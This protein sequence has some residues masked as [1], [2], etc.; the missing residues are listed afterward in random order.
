MSERVTMELNYDWRWYTHASLYPIFRDVPVSWKSLCI[1]TLVEGG[2]HSAPC[3]SE[4]IKEANILCT[5]RADSDFHRLALD[6][7]LLLTV[8]IIWEMRTRNRAA[9]SICTFRT[10]AR[11]CF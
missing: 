8:T 11:L 1:A 9:P 10:D 5:N 3:S 7:F 2:L 4:P 6:Q